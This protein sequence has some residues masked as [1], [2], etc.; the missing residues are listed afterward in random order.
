MSTDQSRLNAYQYHK[1]KFTKRLWL[2]TVV[3]RLIS[4]PRLVKTRRAPICRQFTKNLF[5]LNA[6]KIRESLRDSVRPNVHLLDRASR[7]RQTFKVGQW[8]FVVHCRKQTR[9]NVTNEQ[10]KS[11]SAGRMFGGEREAAQW[12]FIDE[13]EVARNVCATVLIVRLCKRSAS[14]RRSLFAGIARRS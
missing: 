13:R 14:G 1:R 7:P 10:M 9:R 12:V 4:P 2:P 8:T 6:N 5:S 11:K 3:K